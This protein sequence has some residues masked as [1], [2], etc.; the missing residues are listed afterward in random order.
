VKEKNSM[1][2]EQNKAIVRQMLEE[3]HNGNLDVMNDH[4]GLRPFI[5]HVKGLVDSVDFADQDI[6]Q[7]L[8]DGDS[9]VTR[10]LRNVT[11]KKDF[12]GTP[13]GSK[14]HIETIMIH[15]IQNGKIVEQYTQFGRIG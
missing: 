5:P 14:A 13:A 3:V 12:M 15:K 4:P 1:S 8:T 7:Q 11:F 6:V 10:Y 2:A 9:V